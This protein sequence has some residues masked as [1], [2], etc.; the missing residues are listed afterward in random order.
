MGYWL[1][2][3]VLASW[4]GGG[5]EMDLVREASRLVEP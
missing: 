3:T 4:S 2:P 1:M 5:T